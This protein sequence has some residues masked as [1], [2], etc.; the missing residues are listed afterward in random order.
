L[1]TRFCQKYGIDKMAFLWGLP[2]GVLFSTSYPPFP[3]WALFFAF[4]PL[5]VYWYKTPRLRNVF[6]SGFTAQFLFTFIGF[7]WIAHTATEYGHIPF[8]LSI[9]V[10]IGFC[11]FASLNLVLAGLVAKLLQARYPLRAPFFFLLVASL[12]G[13]CDWVYPMIFPWN[14]GYPLYFSHLGT[15]QLGEFVGFQILGTLVYLANSLFALS[16]FNFPKKGWSAPLI[17][18]VV[19]L[20]LTETLG[21]WT[22]NR[23]P[24]D[25]KSVSVLLIQ[26]NIGNYDKFVAERGN[27]YQA[28][29]VEKFFTQARLG[30]EKA[31][32]EKKKP[33]LMIF[34]ETSYPASLDPYFADTFYT[35]QLTDFIDKYNTPAL[36]GS[37]S[38]DPPQILHPKTYN[39]FF[40]ILPHS[41]LTTG[42]RKHLLLAFG[43][44]FPGSDMIPFLKTI[45]PAISDFGRGSGPMVFT[46][47]GIGYTPLICYEGLDTNYV[48]EAVK[49]GGQILVNVTNDS[50]FG[51]NFEPYQHMIMTAART[52][53]YRRPMIRVTNTGL[54]TVIDKKGKTLLTGPQDEPWT[55][56]TDVPYSSRP[57]HTVFESV[58]PY[59]TLI[60]LSLV[61]II[62][63]VGRLI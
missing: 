5:W 27:G 53:E 4:A 26:P 52:I 28:P 23:L 14:T 15:A 18:F 45:V 47:N 55:I 31:F 1:P 50:W 33:D 22:S 24:V 2:T 40:P 20:F 46:I 51:K 49:I 32:A 42:Y 63:F 35:R 8:A 29:V 60:L 11:I 25:D 19:G 36:V 56:L 10:L 9:L 12:S 57:M 37:Y 43:E 13:L 30:L 59:V 16:Y 41:P 39:G 21:H 62:F 54:T 7:N 34:P 61:L 3:A 38:D 44:Y 17:I 58:E 6:V 48:R